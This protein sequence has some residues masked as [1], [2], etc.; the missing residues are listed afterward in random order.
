MKKKDLIYYIIFLLVF[1]V[2]LPL[3]HVAGLVSTNTISL[4]GRYFCF[5][6][7]AL[8]IDLIWGYTGI[9]S[10]CQAFFFCLGSYGIAMHMLL[11]TTA[12]NGATV[13]DFMVWN[14]IE[15]LPLAWIP[16][17]S[18]GLTLVLCLVVPALFAFLI[19]YVLFRSRI[20]GVYMAIITQALAL[21]MWLLFLR[22]E[23]KLGGTNGLTDFKTLLGF[24]LADTGT[25]MALYG[26]SLAVLCGAYFLCNRMVHSK[27]GKVLLAIRDSE[28]RI[29]YA[30]Y[31][32]NDYKLAVFVVAALLAAVAGMLYVPQTGI[33]TP[34]RMDVKASV[35]MVMWVALGGRG[36]LKG[37]V[38]GALLVNYL[39]SICTSLFP[40]SWLYILGFF[41]VITVLFFDKGLVGVVDMAWQK[42]T[43]YKLRR[44]AIS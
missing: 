1:A 17:Q 6:I 14:K 44:A 30:A 21:A 32:V 40:D 33:I 7:A 9:L 37:A 10:M 43:A 4:W 28:S 42:W 41:F 39:Y 31:N 12:A 27:F 24:R 15:T 23:T 25:K 26:L 13:P 36:N 22:N 19:G 29:S 16:F 20:K 35:E 18:S 8:G 38:I 5:A 3:G 34:G 2:I 11:K